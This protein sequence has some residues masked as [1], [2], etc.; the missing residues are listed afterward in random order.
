MTAPRPVSTPA[1]DE[2][3]RT[4]DELIES[5]VGFYRSWFLSLGVE[6][7]LLRAVADAGPRGVSGD[8]LARAAQVHPPAADAW[9]R[10]AYAHRIVELASEDGETPERFSLPPVLAQI[11][12]DEDSSYYL[13]G[14]F[15][16]SI[17]STLDYAE[18]AEFFRTGRTLPERA[19]RYHRA[20]ERVT[21]EDTTLFVEDG[22]P[23]L[24]GL[25]RRL[26]AGID[27][28]DVACGGGRWLVEMAQRFPES[29][30][31]GVEYEPDSVSRAL[32]HVA[33]AGVEKRV[34]IVPLDPAAMSYV[35]A[36]D[37]AYCQDALHELPRPLEALRATWQALR[38]GGLLVVFDWCLPSRVEDYRTALG[39]LA[40]GVQIDELYQGTRLMTREEFE[41]LF[42]QAGIGPLRRLELLA[43][44]TLFVASR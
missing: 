22:L 29:R 7:G 1:T 41:A 31:T 24:Q 27:V 42:E 32:R 21:V 20:I 8:E 11:L 37:L 15:V 23:R 28:V 17:V 12:L 9:L 30:F 35:A 26:A 36:F 5:L 43:G 2:L 19:P 4:F 33:E 10:G 34:E 38:P 6:L 13:G 3:D 18:L 39:E 16:R 40:W 44:A 25:S 14:Q